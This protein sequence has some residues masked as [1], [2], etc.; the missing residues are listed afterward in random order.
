[1]YREP[2]LQ[3]K[4]DE[5]AVLWHIWYKLYLDKD[6]LAKTAR[7]TWCKCADELGEMIQEEYKTNPRYHEVKMFWSNDKGSI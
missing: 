5:C 1:V 7:K 3:K 4:S 2:H 6:P